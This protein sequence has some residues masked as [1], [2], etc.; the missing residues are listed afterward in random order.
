[1]LGAVVVQLP[2]STTPLSG[3]P[4]SGVPESGMLPELLL[5]VLPELL[6][7]LPD[8]LPELLDE[9]P[10]LLLVLPELDE[11]LSS[12][13][14][15]L[16]PPLLVPLP[17]SVPAS[18]EESESVAS[19]VFSPHATITARVPTTRAAAMLR[20]VAMRASG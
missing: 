17:P 5:D 14:V 7:V 16:E 1:M 10:E 6:D 15:P 12:S 3:F 11:L 4:E 13:L 8:V 20:Y 18:S 19:L 9:P 2:A